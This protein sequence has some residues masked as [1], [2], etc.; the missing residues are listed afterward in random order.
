[1]AEEVEMRF[2][3]SIYSKDGNRPLQIGKNKKV[4]DMMKDELGGK[5]NAGLVALRAKLTCFFDRKLIYKEQMLF[6][7]N[8]HEFFMINKHNRVLHRDNDKRKIQIHVIMALARGYS[9]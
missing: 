5:I 2:D 8:K 1:M 9:A 6:D 7:N 4:I 3:I